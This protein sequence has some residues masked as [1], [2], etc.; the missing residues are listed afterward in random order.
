[1]ITHHQAVAYRL[2]QLRIFAEGPSVRSQSN[3]IL[4]SLRA[5]VHG[6][7]SIARLGPRKRLWNWLRRRGAR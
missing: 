3:K 4:P 2:S 6:A 1:M 5:R 7:C